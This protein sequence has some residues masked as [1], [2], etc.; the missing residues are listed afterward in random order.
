MT[1]CTW[2]CKLQHDGCHI[3]SRIC[4]FLR[5]PQFWWGWSFSVVIFM[6]CFVYYWLFVFLSFSI[7]VV[8]LFSTEKFWM[9]IWYLSSFL[10]IKYIFLC[11]TKYILKQAISKY[12]IKWMATEILLSYIFKNIFRFCKYH[13]WKS[14]FN[15]SRKEFIIQYYKLHCLIL[16]SYESTENK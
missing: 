9:F 3:L 11:F 6:L 16:T 7:G 14:E 12:F 5:S 10:Y 2:W 13:V 15:W 8:S 1:S 4:V